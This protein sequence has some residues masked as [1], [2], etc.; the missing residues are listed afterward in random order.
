MLASYS[1]VGASLK[2]RAA[3]FLSRK[4]GI[5]TNIFK[6]KDPLASLKFSCENNSQTA[7]LESGKEKYSFKFIKN[8]SVPGANTPKD[9]IEIIYTQDGKPSGTITLSL[10]PNDNM[11]ETVPRSDPTDKFLVGNLDSLKSLV[12]LM[13]KEDPPGSGAKKSICPMSDYDAK[14]WNTAIEIVQKVKPDGEINLPAELNTAITG[15]SK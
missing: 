12:P 13:T 7:I 10:E 11:S 14:A 1:L 5:Q 3:D 15:T 8:G 2:K 4:S 6:G 9:Q